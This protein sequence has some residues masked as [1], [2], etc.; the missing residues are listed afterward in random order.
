MAGQRDHMNRSPV[1][2]SSSEPGNTHNRFGSRRKTP[3]DSESAGGTVVG[4]DASRS[5]WASSFESF[6]DYRNVFANITVLAPGRIVVDGRSECAF[7]PL[8]GP[9]RWHA[10][11][12]DGSII[13]WRVEE[14]G[15][16]TSFSFSFEDHLELREVLAVGAAHRRLHQRRQHL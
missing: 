9:A 2:R 3:N 8:R 6:P 12:V 5:T 4:K 13:E 7:E 10:A 1:P 11:V 16:S 14:P 15:G